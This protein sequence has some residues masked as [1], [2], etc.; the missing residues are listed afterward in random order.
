MLLA[1]A[2]FN[3]GSDSAQVSATQLQKRS[4]LLK[5]YYGAVLLVVSI[6]YGGCESPLKNFKE[7][8][9]LG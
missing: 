5:S 2:S 6:I 4:L 9:E 1:V 3:V 8:D 7:G